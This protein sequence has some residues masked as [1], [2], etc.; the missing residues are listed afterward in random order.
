MAAL[1]TRYGY[2]AQAN[3]PLVIG[4][5]CVGVLGALFERPRQ[6]TQAEQT[7]AVSLADQCAQ[8]LH[9]AQLLA[10]ETTA[11][12]TAQ[13]LNRLVGALSAATG[14]AEVGKVILDYARGLGAT[15]AAV[16]EPAA[17]DQL[18]VLAARGY[19]GPTGPLAT[20]AA[21]P[22]AH[23]VRTAQPVWRGARSAEAWQ[24]DA[25]DADNPLPVQVAVPLVVGDSAVGALGMR[26]AD[27]AHTFTPEERSM[28][29]TL[30]GQ[31]AQALD[32]ARLYQAEH[33]V[34]QTLQRSLL[35][36][37]VPEFDRL[38]LATRY[39]PGAP[40]VAAG[41]D[42]Y[43]VLA[44]DEHQV[45]IVVG[46][47]VGQGAA[48]AAVMG[49][50][51]TVL[52]A[53]L[54]D[55]HGPA[56]ALERLDRLAVRIP[57]ALASTAAVMIVDLDSGRLSWAR[58]G[59]PPPLLVEP[60]DVRYLAEGAGGPLGVTRRPPYR[61][62]VTRIEPG[63]CVLLY[64]DGLIERRGQVIDEGLNHLATT[65]TKLCAQPPTTLLDGLLAAALPDTGPADDIALI[66]AR[67]LPAPLHQQLPA[68]PAQL[69]RL[70]RA[71]RDW[72]DAGA[73][74]AA[75]G[76]DLQIT[77]GRPPPMPSNTPMP[78]PSDQASSAT[79]SPAGSDGAIDV[80]VRDFGHWRTE[81][82]ADNSHRGRG[83]VIIR[84]IATDV[85]MDTTPEG[86]QVRFRLPAPP[87]EPAIGPPP[88][89]PAPTRETQTPV[90]AELH[91]HPQPDGGRRL[92]LR[93]ELDL[94]AVTALRRPL[95]GQ[96]HAPGPITLDLR[97]VDYLSSAGVGLLIQAAQHA[98]AQGIPWRLQLAPRSLVARFLT[99]I[100]FDTVVFDTVVRDANG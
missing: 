41:G 72:A 92:E 75:L 14:V 86:T 84:A 68:E 8:A 5:R 17:H 97:A 22:L 48:A 6:F 24:H 65:A 88:A 26:F 53:Y 25:F 11:R 33:N 23:A 10:T 31:C 49:Q 4:K 85:T 74:A 63:A 67:Y 32:R 12:L 35:P 36:G 94:A 43:D 56:A 38:A 40:D 54:L 3:L 30:G 69:P 59:H 79:Y 50:L 37:R 1:V 7:A 90:P 87:A 91:V 16:V 81:S 13:R 27:S 47:V 93:G 19:P 45:A 39:L 96:L 18:T 21:H 62:A 66:A 83:L 77:V 20:D 64:T 76:D 9:R 55:D 34:A 80:E 29:L 89:Q 15:A 42:W 60:D 71:V 52:A 70:R 95:L 57:G 73:A 44:L 46:D 98:D 100:G 82:P 58:A 28:I 78:T 2:P 99:L 61:E 51:R